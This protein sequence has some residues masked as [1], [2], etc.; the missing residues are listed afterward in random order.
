MRRSVTTALILSLAL[1][2]GAAHAECDPDGFVTGGTRTFDLVVGGRTATMI[3]SATVEGD[4]VVVQSTFSGVSSTTTW[5]CTE[6]GLTASF[7]PGTGALQA[8]SGTMPP[9]SQWKVGKTWPGLSR[10]TTVSGVTMN[11]TSQSRI[12]AQETVTTPAGT[13]TA[14]RVETI[15][16]HKLT[17][18][19][20]TTLPA[21]AAEAMNR[22]T[23]VTLWYARGVGLVKEVNGDGSFTL[24]LTQISR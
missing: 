4:T 11:S 16:K 9:A 6:Q 5:T 21:G 8:D 15:T 14:F 12:A 13:F 23:T 7:G 22:D 3:T 2:A 18:P 20:G 17:V 10:V 19:P 1:L 24:T